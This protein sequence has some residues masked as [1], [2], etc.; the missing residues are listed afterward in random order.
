M[1]E[2]LVVKSNAL[3]MAKYRLTLNEQRLILYILA[4]KV[5]KFDEEFGVY[6]VSRIELEETFGRGM[7]YFDELVETVN[8][9]N[10][11]KLSF[12]DGNDWIVGNW[13]SMAKSNRTTREITVEFP[14]LLKPY[15][16]DLKD[17]F[18]KYGLSNIIYIKSGYS[19]RLF[20][21]LKQRVGLKN[22]IFTVEELKEFLGIGPDEYRLFGH[23]KDKVLK[24]AQK[25][26]NEN[27]DIRFTF[28][29]IKKGRKFVSIKFFVRASKITRQKQLPSLET[30]PFN[31]QEL[32]DRLISFGASPSETDHFFKKFPVD[33]IERN[34]KLCEQ[35]DKEGKIH[36]SKRGF[37]RK[38]IEL[39]F[40]YVDLNKEA[41]TKKENDQRENIKHII[42]LWKD[43][44]G[45]P[46]I[47]KQIEEFYRDVGHPIWQGWKNFV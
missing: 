12:H 37:L 29:P 20:E 28:E 46:E 31:D 35:A 19:I 13:V 38:S 9:L 44:K 30:P 40:A 41:K 7:A 16:L 39:D 33:L 3:I 27:A 26:I 25:Q 24:V 14:Q 15:L 23:F 4:E 34:L 42:A 17:K 2:K 43:G 32:F 18:T 11:R 22:I 5:T 8:K 21:L 1:V 45:T 10:D 47:E 36:S 6:K